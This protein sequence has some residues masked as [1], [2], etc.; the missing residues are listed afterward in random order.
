MEKW[1]VYDR[2]GNNTGKTKTRDDIFLEG[3]YHLTASL[4]IIN[5]DGNL[6]IQKR[7]MTKRIHPGIWNITGGSSISGETSEQACIREVFEEIGLSLQKNEIKLL[8]RSFG[9]DTIFDDYVIVCDFPLGEA[10]LQPDEVS[11]A[12]W[13]SIEEIK[14]LFYK[15]QFLFDDIRELDKV[16][17]YLNTNFTNRS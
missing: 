14:D 1:D 6:L 15:G 11:E 17:A 12:K 8:S 7:S 13:V 3:E 4:W 16:I 2:Q 9:K 10:K 5:K